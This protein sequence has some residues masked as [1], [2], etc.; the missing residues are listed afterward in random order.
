MLHIKGITITLG[1]TRIDLSQE[2]LLL[3]SSV[4]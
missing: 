4:F 3:T 1:D 2:F